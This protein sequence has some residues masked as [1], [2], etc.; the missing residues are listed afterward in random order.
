M[1]YFTLLQIFTLMEQI[2]YATHS[3]NIGKNPEFVRLKWKRGFANN[4]NYYYC[5]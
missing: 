3:V 2:Y 1:I 4:N 5:Q